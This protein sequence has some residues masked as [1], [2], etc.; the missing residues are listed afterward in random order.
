MEENRRARGGLKIS[1][2]KGGYEEEHKGTQTPTDPRRL[3]RK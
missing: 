3:K 1:K 2:R